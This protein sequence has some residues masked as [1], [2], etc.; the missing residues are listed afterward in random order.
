[1]LDIMG[2]DVSRLVGATKPEIAVFSAGIASMGMEILAGRM[3]APEFGSSIYTWGSIIGVFLASLSIGYLQG[4]KSAHIEAS[5]NRIASL[6]LYVA[7]YIAVL[8]FASDLIIRVTSGIPTPPMFSSLIP[9][10]VLFG[11]PVY[12]LGFI[13]PYGAELSNRQNKGHAA[14]QVYAIGTFGSIIGAFGTTFFLIPKFSVELI[15]FFFGILLIV[16]AIRIVVPKIQ[17]HTAIKIIFVSILLLGSVA[18][19]SAGIS[20]K[21]NIVY[22]TQ[23]PY[24]EL[25][26]VDRGDIRTLYLGGQRHSA[27]SL[28]N[29]TRHIFDYTR[30]FHTPFLMEDKIQNVLF[31]GGGGFSGP[32]IF[33]EKYNNLSI[34]VVEIDPEVIET[35]KKY[36][37]LKKYINSNKPQI[38]VYNA[39]GRQFLQSTNKTYDLIILDAYKKDKVP[40]HLTTQEFMELT[41][42]KLDDDGIILANM[43]SSPTGAGSK[44]YRSEYKTMKEVYPNVYSF[45]TSNTGFVQNIELIATKN[46]TRINKT[47]LQKLNKQK[48]IGINLTEEINFYQNTGKIKTTDVPVLKD[49]KAPVS[50]LLDPMLGQKYIIEENTSK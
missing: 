13:S 35:S 49:D 41:N 29:P 2:F 48:N 15:G 3:I 26:V 5:Q 4:G 16:T 18:G 30:Y 44:I 6:L 9:V 19:N 7:G 36:F 17:R 50:Q 31:I 12:F 20:V 21:G 45:T 27:M 25:Q 40:F 39:D 14:G 10:I 32:K 11:P 38:N 46:K 8:I 47:Q 23:T 24:Q 1:M 33:A 22:Q 34:D 28:R 43:I 37:K 42:N